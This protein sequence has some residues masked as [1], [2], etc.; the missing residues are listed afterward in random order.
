[1]NNINGQQFD[2]FLVK[3]SPNGN[4]NWAKRAGGTN[5]DFPRGI[6]T[7]ENGNIF[8]TGTFMSAS[9]TFGSSTLTNSNYSKFF[10]AKYDSNGNALWAKGAGGSTN[11]TW[12]LGIT[13]DTSGNVFTT[14]YF[15]N[16]TISFDSY[17]LTNASSGKMDIFVNKLNGTTGI[18][19][20]NSASE[21]LIFPNPFSYQT[22]FQ[23]DIF[24]ENAMLTVD[25]VFGQTVKQIKNISGHLVIM[26]RDNLPS[27]LYFIRLTQDDKII[28]TKKI[29]ITD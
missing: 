24:F 1:M 18:V 28:A 4:L 5:S 10:I 14:G 16:S 22:H 3:Y 2:L 12:G 8:L 15:Q 26:Q 6:S 25:N 9:I 19:E 21:I 17:T 13:T 27:G 20:H 7:D 11:Y 23:S 29:I